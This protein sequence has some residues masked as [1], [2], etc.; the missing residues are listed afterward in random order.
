MQLQ[1]LR[2]LALLPRCQPSLFF[3]QPASVRSFAAALQV[4]RGRRARVRVVG[5]RRR[6]D[7]AVG[8]AREPAVD[9]GQ[10]P[11]AIDRLE[12]RLARP[13]VAE[14]GMIRP[15]F[16]RDRGQRRRGLAEE[17]ASRQ[18]AEGRGGRGVQP[19]R[20]VDPAVAEGRGDRVGIVEE[21]QL[22]P[23]DR[24]HGRALVGGR[25]VV[26][27]GSSDG[28]RDEI[29]PSAGAA[30]ALAGSRTAWSRSSSTIAYGP[31]PT[32]CDRTGRPPSR[33]PACR[34]GGAPARSAGSRGPRTRRS[35]GSRSKRTVRGSTAVAVTPVHDPRRGPRRPD[36]GGRRP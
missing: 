29:G 23:V 34:A 27:R 35:R 22:D 16:R 13:G 33:R 26:A 8:A 4:V 28:S 1:P 31:D 12:E 19:G 20:R 24:G 36:P 6:R 21:G 11:P 30:T 10:D 25:P 3:V 5:P 14:L 15:R 18:L 32:G 2:R 17:P 9:D 7:Q